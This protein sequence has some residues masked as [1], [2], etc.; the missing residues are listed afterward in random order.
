MDFQLG[1][2]VFEDNKDIP[3]IPTGD[4]TLDALL[5][6]GFR[7]DIL[8]LLY[9]NKRIITDIL[10]KSIV[11]TQEY[12]I[13]NALSPEWKVIFV[14]ANNRFSPYKISK[15]AVSHSLSPTLV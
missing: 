8:Y 6:G 13:R 11:L 4:D 15:Q 14:D 7:R 2:K 3:I 10:H 5:G 9:G 1:S 12:S